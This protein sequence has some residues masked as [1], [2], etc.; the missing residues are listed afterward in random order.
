MVCAPV[1]AQET[2]IFM[3]S[4]AAPLD[5]T[6][7]LGARQLVR[8][9]DNQVVWIAAVHEVFDEAVL[10][11]DFSPARRSSKPAAGRTLGRGHFFGE[12]GLID[13]RPRTANVIAETDLWAARLPRATYATLIDHER[14]IARGIMEVLVARIGASRRPRSGRRVQP[15]RSDPPPSMS[16][17]ARFVPRLRV[18]RAQGVV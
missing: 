14:A 18:R 11:A 9:R 4:C 7:G 1:C 5:L 6:H 12:L 16:C 10:R 8:R 17:V 2:A 13:G 3:P 15:V